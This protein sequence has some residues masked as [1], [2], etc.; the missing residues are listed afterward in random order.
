MEA[1]LAVHQ[2]LSGLITAHTNVEKFDK[3]LDKAAANGGRLYVNIETG[4]LSTK[5]TE[6]SVQASFQLL[7]EVFGELKNTENLSKKQIS[8][9][10]G[11]LAFA[12]TN[13]PSKISK[14]F[15]TSKG[16]DKAAN[17]HQAKLDSKIKAET[18]NKLESAVMRS[19]GIAET[20]G[21]SVMK[22]SPTGSF[23]GLKGLVNSTVKEQVNLPK[24]NNNVIAARATLKEAK[25]PE[26][27]KLAEVNLEKANEDRFKCLDKYE[28]NKREMKNYVS[29]LKIESRILEKHKK[30]DA[31]LKV[32]NL[33]KCFNESGEFEVSK[34]AEAISDTLIEALTPK[35]QGALKLIVTLPNAEKQIETTRNALSEA[36]KDLANI[37]N[38]KV[39][40]AEVQS[41]KEKDAQDLVGR[42]EKRLKTQTDQ[43]TT[44]LERQLPVMKKEMNDLLVELKEYSEILGK[45]ENTKAK[46]R[47]ENIL[48]LFDNSGDL[49]FDNSG[50][51]ATTATDA[52][53]VL[54]KSQPDYVFIVDY[55]NKITTNYTN[56]WEEDNLLRSPLGERGV[57]T[58]NEVLDLLDARITQT[59]NKAVV[60]QM[61]DSLSKLDIALQK[62]QEP[63]E[64]LTMKDMIG[65]KNGQQ[66][67]Y[68]HEQDLSKLTDK[69][70]DIIE[71][72]AQTL[73]AD[74]KKIHTELHS[75]NA[76]INDPMYPLIEKQFNMIFE[77][78]IC[79]LTG[80]VSLMLNHTAGPPAKEGNQIGTL[81]SLVHQERARRT[82]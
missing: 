51:L 46:E 80:D 6:G 10:N 38:N 66:H 24:V 68:L 25:T 48:Q 12:S 18:D 1:R 82:G 41:T 70:L 81:L 69:Q 15:T 20:I 17:K 74:L 22:E 71:Q 2:Q 21:N 36:Q 50:D 52:A 7:K 8:T 73:S 56:T 58:S 79:K 4:S 60:A 19:N 32:D 30:N 57:E 62:F 16:L 49:L 39:D 77:A 55:D 26:Q 37:L 64:G 47:V 42:T 75:K 67:S 28:K 43:L 40:D 44:T 54:A 34:G 3:K 23:A 78:P 63:V 5:K 29:T 76:S 65:A 45:L 53:K 11:K 61:R 31:K 35:I 13:Q 59:E 14:L 33:L 72:R 27:H 9:I